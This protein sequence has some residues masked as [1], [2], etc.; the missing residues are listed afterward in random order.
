MTAR[1]LV[2]VSVIGVGQILAW[3]A[4]FYLTAVIAPAIVRETGWSLTAVVAGHS[5]G[6]LAA[7]LAAPSAGRAIEAFGGRRVLAAGSIF[8]ACGL[9][10]LAAARTQ[11]VFY[12][13]WVV[14]GAGMA[15]GLYDAAFGALGQIFRS[16]A[17]QAIT[18]VTLFGGLA[19]TICWPL[20]AAMVEH[21][22]W[23][24][25]CLVYAG[26]HLCV[27]APLH[28]WLVPPPAAPEHD[29]QAGAR[30]EPSAPRA[31]LRVFWLVAAVSTLA[32][33]IASIV[34]V[35][36]IAILQARGLPLAAAVGMGAIFGPAQVGARIV[37]RAV[38]RFY[39]PV[40]TLLGSTVL[41]GCGLALLF[42]RA[43]L[44]VV[45]GAL[46]LYGAGNG[47]HSIAK[48]TVPLAV[49]GP[50]N[51]ARLMG[52]LAAPAMVAQALSPPLAAIALADHGAQVTLALL[53]G[54][55]ALNIGLCVVLL[56][57]T[58]DVRAQG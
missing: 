58:R 19:S 53:A 24:T 40:W 13:A 52:R 12:A 27:T 26:V 4:S 5:V 51:Y 11:P 22:G 15:C 41:V 33:A 30:M 20:T 10:L 28:L 35:H 45:A 38:G 56:A 17:R 25:A 32:M 37:E 7:G 9:A 34:S 6:L 3:G 21:F 46:I 36:L 49:F 47:I 57:W 44:I 2:T 54:A 43:D 29:A 39:H 14:L 18:N 8:F 1:P 16:R 55:A 23:R 42:A 48:G 50:H 31:P